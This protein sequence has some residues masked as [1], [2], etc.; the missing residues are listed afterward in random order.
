MDNGH[1]YSCI[2][3]LYVPPVVIVIVVY[4]VLFSLA[5]TYTPTLLLGENDPVM[6]TIR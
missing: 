6:V 2:M 3:L 5:N 4:S 1:Y